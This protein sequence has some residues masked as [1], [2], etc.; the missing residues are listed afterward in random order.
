[1]NPALQPN[2]VGGYPLVEY[3]D[4]ADTTCNGY[5][6]VHTLNGSTADGVITL[7]PED[8]VDGASSEGWSIEPHAD[9]QQRLLFGF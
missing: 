3:T 8:M 7:I 9:H 4:D 2:R 1:M 6:Y 5:S